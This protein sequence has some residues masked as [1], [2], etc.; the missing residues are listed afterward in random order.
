MIDAEKASV[1]VRHARHGVGYQANT[2]DMVSGLSISA[3]SMP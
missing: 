3:K 1:G 2:P